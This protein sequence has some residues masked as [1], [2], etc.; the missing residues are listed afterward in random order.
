MSDV[1]VC[2]VLG[3]IDVDKLGI[4]LPHEHLLWD[5]TLYL[6]KVESFHNSL[7][8]LP[9]TIENLGDIR[10]DALLCKDNLVQLDID[11]A[12]QEAMFFKSAGG[13]T[14][15]DCSSIGVGRNILALKRIAESTGLNIIAGTGFYIDRSHPQYVKQKNSEELASMM[16][17]EIRRGVDNTDVRCGII[18]EIGTSFPITP[19]EEK[20]LKAAVYAH[21]K[22]NVP[23]NIH[24]DPYAKLGHT[25]LDIVEQEGAD[26]GRVVMSHTDACGFDK[27]YHESLAKRGCY[28]EFDAFGSEVYYDSMGDNQTFPGD[29]I[30][31]PTDFERIAG[32]HELIRQG[33]VSQL[34]LSHD[35]CYKMHL[36]RFG[37][38]GYDH[39]LRH[40]IPKLKKSGVTDDQIHTMLIENPK[41]MLG[42]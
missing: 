27:E 15:V 5:S 29:G 6:P 9:V 39:V 24:P 40:I 14:M 21:Q 32:V 2:S 10:R 35:V 37:G 13:K 41:N 17:D 28:V 8:D 42:S 31:D 26:L 12:I 25:I 19:N 23:I 1:K 3:E 16:V 7:E 11:L 4:T 18:G 20:V 22:T 30:R 38:Y 34:L 36:K 33:Y